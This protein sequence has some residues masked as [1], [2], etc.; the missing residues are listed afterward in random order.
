M[1]TIPDEDE[2][3]AQLAALSEAER[4]LDPQ[5]RSRRSA[6]LSERL[7]DCLREADALGLRDTG[8]HLDMAVNAIERDRE[9]RRPEFS[10]TSS[11]LH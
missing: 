9:P 1:F 6:I 5:E 11:R 3:L 10:A 7:R 8:L 4:N 2:L